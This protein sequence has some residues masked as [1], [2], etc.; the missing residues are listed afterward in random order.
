MELV[1]PQVHTDS[2][3]KVFVSFYL[4]KKRFRLYNG[5]R[6][7]SSTNPNSFPVPQRLNIG[8][9]LAA[10]VYKYIS[11]G[12]VLCGYRSNDDLVGNLSDKEYLHRA[13]KNKLKGNYSDK[14]KSMLQFVYGALIE[15]V[16]DS[17]IMEE[18]VYSFL[19]KYGCGSSYNTIRRHLNVLFNEAE[20]IG[21]QGTP[22]KTIK[23]KKAKAVLHKPFKNIRLVL[24]DLLSFS[25]KLHLCCLL[26][27]GCL[28]RPHREIRELCWGDFTDN[29]SHI[30]LSGHRN[31]SGKNRIVP[32]PQFVR[33]YLQRQEPHHNV[34]TNSKS[35]HNPDYF[36][37]LWSRYKKKSIIL[38]DDQTL[39]SFRHT[40]AINVYH[41]T[42]S[43]TKL[44][45]AM[46]HSS[47]NV[48]L[49]YLRGLEIP[50]LNEND[51][52]ELLLS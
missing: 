2:N 3:N 46:G 18:D 41:K 51:M 20:R 47:L 17:T 29:L 22:M 40:G 42:G 6:I 30:R 19:E 1:Y 36:K 5:K 7:G 39:Y 38:D 28:L 8:N 12:G 13:L 15:H 44:Q 48:S 9:L 14:Y 26:T 35:I 24:D 23:S 45:Q 34:F 43:L 4:N 33:P 25:P 11:N 37:T 21:M 10:E 49:T 16:S 32:V 31:K 50:E 52:P 27:Y